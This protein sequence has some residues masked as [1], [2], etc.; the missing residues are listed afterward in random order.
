MSENIGEERFC[1]VA[2][3]WRFCFGRCLHCFGR[4]DVDADANG[5]AE[6]TLFRAKSDLKIIAKKDGPNGEWRRLPGQ[7]KR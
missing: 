7:P 1:L 3:H 5:I 2:R 6:R 4:C